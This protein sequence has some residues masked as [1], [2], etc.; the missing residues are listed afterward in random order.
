MGAPAAT[1]LLPGC[2]AVRY[3]AEVLQRQKTV[4]EADMAPLRVVGINFDHM[5]MGDLLRAA[6]EHPDTE[7]A[8]VCDEDRGRMQAAIAA[9]GIPP[10]R[11]F[12]DVTECLRVARPDI[13]EV[14]AAP[15][16]HAEYVA[17]IAPFDTHI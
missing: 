15:S 3:V 1:S 14:C 2:A 11:V 17:A 7:F 5:H 12:T 9:F 4:R 16:R 13:A 6:H 10:E 8:G